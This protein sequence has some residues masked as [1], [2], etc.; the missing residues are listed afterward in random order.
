MSKTGYPVKETGPVSPWERFA[1]NAED[2]VHV[3]PSL[4]VEPLPMRRF[5][6]L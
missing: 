6:P 2:P 5:V 4:C 3:D 1:L